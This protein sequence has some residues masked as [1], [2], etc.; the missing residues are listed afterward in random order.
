MSRSSQATPLVRF[1]AARIF[2][3]IHASGAV[4][5]VA[6]TLVAASLPSLE[7]INTGM[8]RTPY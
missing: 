4:I 6:P 1:A 8:P 3:P 2:W 7:V 5:G